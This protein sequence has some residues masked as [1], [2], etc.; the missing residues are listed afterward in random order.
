[1]GGEASMQCGSP[2]AMLGG[3]LSWEAPAQWGAPADLVG[4]PPAW[5]ARTAADA[6]AQ[7]G[8]P[9]A[10]LG[11]CQLPPTAC[12]P[13]P[14]PSAPPLVENIGVLE[15]PNLPETPR[16]VA[17]P[18]GPASPLVLP[19][20]LPAESRQSVGSGCDSV[21][22]LVTADASLDAGPWPP[23]AIT[24]PPVVPPVWPSSPWLSPADGMGLSPC[25]MGADLPLLTVPEDT[26]V[27]APSTPSAASV[28]GSDKENMAGLLNLSDKGPPILELHKVCPPREMETP[29][30]K[31]S[32][33]RW[34]FRKDAPCFVPREVFGDSPVEGDSSL[35][36]AETPEKVSLPDA[37]FVTARAQMLR[38]RPQDSP[39]RQLSAAALYA[40]TVA[41]ESGR[42]P[43]PPPPPLEARR[44]ET[45]ESR[46]QI[47]AHAANA[48]AHLA[49]AAAIAEIAE[50]DASPSTPSGR[51]GRRFRGGRATGRSP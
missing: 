50:K 19:D 13:P 40:A 25:S 5:E 1:M 29:P 7:C 6:G 2:A 21:G 23:V 46:A 49:Q 15:V 37:D 14:P 4:G 9:A 28:G 11:G 42:A 34:A 12:M 10:M 47:R 36:V 26:W 44:S 31:A 30:P 20:V 32:S 38:L 33:G 48:R 43:T 51:G 8:L 41:F 18:E 39:K 35:V 3:V 24:A 27:Q 16:G 45:T 17:E 22:E